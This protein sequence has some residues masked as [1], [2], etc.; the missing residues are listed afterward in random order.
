MA[1]VW[2][3]KS[4]QNTDFIQESATSK[5]AKDKV[6]ASKLWDKCATFVKL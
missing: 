6:L 2:V 3:A 1:F 4:L 5:A